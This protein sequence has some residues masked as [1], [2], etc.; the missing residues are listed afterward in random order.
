MDAMD[1]LTEPQEELPE[2]SYGAEALSGRRDV[3]TRINSLLGRKGE[4]WADTAADAVEQ[5]FPD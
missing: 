2:V 5:H 1:D 4:Y 3:T